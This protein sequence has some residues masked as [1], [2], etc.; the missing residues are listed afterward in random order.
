MPARILFGM[1]EFQNIGMLDTHHSHICAAAKCALLDGVCRLGKDSPETYRPAGRSAAGGDAVAGGAQMVEGKTGAAACPL[2][3]RRM[4]DGF[5][6]F[7]DAVFYR[8]NKTCAEHS[9]RPDTR[10]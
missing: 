3:H 7:F 9:L 8:Q 6:N 2:D 1:N 4:L 5:E 10:S